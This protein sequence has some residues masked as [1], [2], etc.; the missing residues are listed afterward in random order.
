M[1][2]NRVV[3][4]VHPDEAHRA[5]AADTRG[6]ADMGAR[7][8]GG[9]RRRGGIAAAMFA[10][11]VLGAALVSVTGPASAAAITPAAGVTLKAAISNL[12]VNVKGGVASENAD[13][14]QYGCAATYVNDKWKVVP[15]G[16]GTYHIIA[17][18]SNRCLNVE[19]GLLTNNTQVIQYP[20]SAAG[21]NDRWRF[22]PVAGKPT[23][24]I[25]AEHSGKCLNVT[26]GLTTPGT[27][28]IQYTCSAVPQLNEQWYFA[29]TAS[30][31]PVALPVERNTPVVAVQGAPLAGALVGP[32]TYA[33]VDNLGRLRLGHQSEPDNDQSLQWS[34]VSGL[35]AFT[36]R[37]TVAAQADGRVEIVAHNST[38]SDVWLATQTAKG[39]ATYGTW[40]D[41]GGAQA[42]QP[43]VAKL[44]D[45][46]LVVLTLA[47]GGGLWHL[48]Q[49]GTNTPYGGWRFI[50]GA[51]LVG[52]P[53]AVTVRDGV[54]IFALDSAGALQTAEYRAGALSDWTSLGGAGLTGTPTAIVYPGYRVRV[55]ARTAEGAVVTKLQGVDG[56]FAADW[57]PV[58]SSVVDGSP[59]A[60]LDPV[61][62]TA[63]V[64]ARGADGNVYYSYETGQAT[65]AWGEWRKGWDFVSSTDPTVVVFN[66]GNGATAWGYV[67]RNSDSQAVLF[68]QDGFGAAGLRASATSAAGFSKHV[69]PALPK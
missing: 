16:D 2:G 48:P 66:R 4:S 64:V 40:Q 41:V 13:I 58:G 20:C 55:F 67:V 30:G 35:E 68:R 26:R 29:P 19:Q 47:A 69:L 36:G 65:G 49:D 32:L 27:P 54:R 46:K 43:T 24:Q 37:P 62:G 15:N 8:S 50:G 33:F 51:N 60:V 61:T 34:T 22:K 5:A 9:F 52:T 44:P 11:T 3:W 25:V 17:T 38:D 18:F 1:A 14:V 23:F 53:A 31:T 45:G 42:Y 28:I 12:C 63:A 10:T 7:I 21:K 56:S 6:K 59:S 57:S 39:A